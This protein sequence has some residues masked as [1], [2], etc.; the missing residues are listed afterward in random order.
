MNFGIF[1]KR[2]KF[3]TKWYTNAIRIQ[4]YFELELTPAKKQI[5]E[6]AVKKVKDKS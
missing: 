5:F 6:K 3:A 1:R 2:I 4:C